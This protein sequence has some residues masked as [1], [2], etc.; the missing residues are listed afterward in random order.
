MS[1]CLFVCALALASLA[2]QVV[3]AAAARDRDHDKLPDRWERRH[4]LSTTTPNARRDPDRDRLSNRR[5][6]RLR[7]HPRRRDTDRD[8]LGDGAEVRRYHTNPRRR[9]TDGDGLTDGAEVNRHHTNPRRPDTD[10]DGIDDGAEVGA[11]SDATDPGS[12]PPPPV[13]PAPPRCDVNATPASLDD[14][15]D[16]APAGQSICL[17]A[18]DYGSFGGASK[19]GP[20]TVRAVPGVVARMRLGFSNASNLVLD[21]LTISG[22]TLSGSTRDVTIRNSAFSGPVTIRGLANANVVLDHNTHLNIDAGGQTSSPA[23]IHLSYSGSTHSGVT[24]QNSLLAGGDSDGVQTGVGVNIINNEFRDILQGG[25]NHTDA[26]QLLGAAG[27][28]IRG[29]YIHHSATGIVAYDGLT[30]ATIERNVVQLPGRRPWGI[31]LYSDDSSIV[32][33]NTL[34]HGSCDFNLPCGIISITRKSQ[35]D[36][37]HGTVVID[38]IATQISVQSGSTIAER[39]HN[40]LRQGAQAGDLI[41]VPAFVGG[42]TPA[43]FA[44]FQLTPISPG[45]NAASD[46]TNVGA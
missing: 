12:V 20:V 42:A 38:N 13:A 9:D 44:A 2:G 30:R 18:G 7:T 46:G 16:A 8:G 25:S 28:V 21:G 27:S 39:H 34:A 10:R 4:G 1:K 15:L 11:G 24:I 26:I 29:N 37:G 17:A 41:G 43:A 31:E 23:R 3:S 36:A 32:R 14:V 19:D 33:H 6:Y 40:L 22:A 35:D 45:V 5:E